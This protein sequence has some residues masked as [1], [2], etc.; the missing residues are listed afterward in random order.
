MALFYPYI[1]LLIWLD[2]EACVK[3]S[4]CQIFEGSAL[5]SLVCDVVENL[6]L[7]WFTVFS[8]GH[9]SGPLPSF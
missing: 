5:L 8:M 3:T 1:W 2:I 9:S 4:E 6:M 7:F